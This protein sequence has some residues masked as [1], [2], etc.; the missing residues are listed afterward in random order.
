MEEKEFELIKDGESLKKI[1]YEDLAKFFDEI[2]YE[3]LVKGLIC[4]EKGIH[5]E[6]E[7]D[8]MVTA[9]L[10][11]CSYSGLL[12]GFFEDGVY[13]QSDYYKDIKK[14]QGKDSGNEKIKGL[15]LYPESKNPTKNPVEI[16]INKENSLYEMQSLVGGYC[17]VISIAEDIDMWI[18]EERKLKD[19]GPSLEFY[20]NGKLI[21]VVVGN[22]LFL[23]N[24]EDEN[25]ERDI[26]SLNDKQIDEIK[27][28]I[29][30]HKI[31][32]L[33]NEDN[34]GM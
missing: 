25:G 30:A 13:T 16:E 34:R 10:D 31:S 17:Q 20:R 21:D 19:Y 6:N 3:D 11:D 4:F 5:D 1:S 26:A 18:D 14:R 8:A 28:F 9:Y 29:E 15:L 2:D 22:V 7:L 12:C 24:K 27:K 32:Y 23:S 33:D